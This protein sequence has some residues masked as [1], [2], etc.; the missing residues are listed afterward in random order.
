MYI[1]FFY[2]SLNNGLVNYWPMDNQ[3]T[4]IVG[5]ANMYNGYNVEFVKDRFGNSNSAIRFTEGYYQVP[6]GVYF[7]G[8]FTVSV[9]I[10]PINV[11]NQWA[12]I[13][14]FGNG[15]LS[16][17][18]Q[19]LSSYSD[20]GQPTFYVYI[21]NYGSSVDPNMQLIIGQW[22]HLVFTLKESVGTLYMN[23]LQISQ[24]NTMYVPRN[25]NRTLNYVG[26]SNWDGVSNLWA[27]L[28][29]LRFYN[30]SMTQ[31]EVNYLFLQQASAQTSNLNKYIAFF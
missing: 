29:D 15:G 20:R 30:R 18:I 1:D 19:F 28:D 12:R 14:D 3:L 8:D 21:Y 31:A 17:N 13:I 2:L 11:F 26:K 9:W 23:G 7:N 4:D 10:K 27:D 22:T 25:V 5:G 16:D 24:T 6:P